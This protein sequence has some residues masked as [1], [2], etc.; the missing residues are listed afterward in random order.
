MNLLKKIAHHQ[1]MINNFA[2][3]ISILR[4]NKNNKNYFFENQ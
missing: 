2:Y 4:N 1:Q 3:E